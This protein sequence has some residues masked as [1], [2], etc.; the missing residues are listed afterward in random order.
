LEDLENQ[1][2]ENITHRIVNMKPTYSMEELGSYFGMSGLM[3]KRLITNNKIEYIVINKRW[4]SQYKKWY[5][6]WAVTGWQLIEMLEIME[7]DKDYI[8][9]LK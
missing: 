2:K 6:K 7:K 5:E 1:S 4:S 8:T 3:A 9:D